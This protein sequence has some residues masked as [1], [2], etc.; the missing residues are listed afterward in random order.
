[1]T[2]VSSEEALKNKGHHVALKLAQLRPKV[3]LNADRARRR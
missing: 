3:R 1:M 2:R